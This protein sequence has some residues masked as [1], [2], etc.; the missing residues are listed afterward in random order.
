MTGCFFS[1][2]KRCVRPG[3]WF[4]VEPAEPDVRPP[5]R[6]R[7]FSRRA[8]ARKNRTVTAFVS[9]LCSLLRGGGTSAPAYAPN[10]PFRRKL[11]Q[12]RAAALLIAL[13]AAPAVA[14]AP[15]VKPIA[16]TQRTLANGLRVFAVPDKGAASVAVQ[17][18]YHVG[19]KDDPR[20]R[21]GFAHLFE[22]LMF[23]GSRNLPAEAF[24]RLTEDVGGANNAATGDDATSYYEVAP[25]NHL[26][27][28]LFAEA[29]RMAAL[30]FDPAGFTSERDVV[31][32]ELRQRTLAEPYGQLLTIDYPALAY[33]THPYAR[34]GIGSLADLQA[35]SIDEVRAFHAFYYRP[36]N[37]VLVV[38]G[39][40][41][42]AQ[43]DRWV[44]RYFAPI[45]RPAWPIPRVTVIEPPRT[46]PVSRTVHAANTPL[47]AVLISWPVPPDRDA[48]VSALDVLSAVLATGDGSRLVQALVYRDGVAQS[49]ETFLDTR[50]GAG[51][52]VA[53]AVLAGGTPVAAGEAA[54]RR[55]IARLH[56]APVTAAELARAKN[57]LLLQALRARETAEGRAAALAAAVL[58]DGDPRATD[59]QLAQISA[60][61]A[62]DVQRVARRYLRDGAAAT[63]R[64]LPATA[65]PPGPIAV[66]STV[67]IA[68]LPRPPHV[69]VVAPAAHPLAPPPPGPPIV[70]TPP[71]VVEARLANGLRVVTVERHD[72]PLVTAAL[73]A[74]GGAATDP[75]GRAGASSLATDLLARGTTTRSA[76]QIAAAV[77]ALGGTLDAAADRDGATLSL[78]VGTQGL[79]PG[80]AVLADVARHPGFAASE[81]ARARGQAIDAVAVQLADPAAIAGLVAS[82][83]VWGG[84]PY[85]APLAGTPASL[86][87]ITAA[88]LRASHAGT[89]RPDQATL[90]LVGDIT[91]ADGAALAGRLFADWRGGAMAPAAPPAPVPPRPRVIVI[92][93]PGAG[94]AAVVVARPGVARASS[95]YYPLL[96]ANA[97]LGGGF[98]SRLNQQVRIARGLAYGASSDVSARRLGGTVSARTQVENGRA[99]DAA[100]LLVAEMARLGRTPPAAGELD[101]RKAA[102]LGERARAV[103]TTDGIAGILADDLL[104]GAAATEL[105]RAAPALAAVDTAAALRAAALFDP[106][107]ASIVIVG[108]VGAMRG[109]RIAFPQAEVI[110]A[111]ALR[112]DRP[113]LR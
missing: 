19:S 93:L 77:E 49:A 24:D 81:V 44:D 9:N 107:A 29:D 12:L 78:T 90:L 58:I 97:V 11:R 108:D 8:L 48:D 98:S 16:Y 100:Q 57:Q 1:A 63:I 101:A 4:G 43:L 53:Y 52:L 94:Q 2:L 31:E 37:A 5:P 70:A 55:E 104:S 112:L 36:D 102:T 21:S 25:A 92:D 72:L 38:A 50:E 113:A 105:D 83:A 59:R 99:V 87:A 64:Y 17:V 91:P 66:A 75:P 82:R 32:A 34:P 76:E 103:E 10:F 95:A 61:T 45:A 89:W 6:R 56:D 22:H 20:G 67:Q 84:A 15:A 30:V 60:V 68:G 106:A 39:G 13:P 74:G 73:V 3:R 18:W 110:A 96:V 51:N 69:P 14:Q 79:A 71:R 47:P 23:K 111:K 42:P 35:A 7:S 40:F 109:L 27:R 85:G 41:D 80:L 26:E 62:S 54:L 28:L 88:D 33:T 46:A 65:A 86:R